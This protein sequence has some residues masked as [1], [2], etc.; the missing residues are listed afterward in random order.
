MA[1]DSKKA[2]RAVMAETKFQPLGVTVD[3]ARDQGTWHLT[4]AALTAARAFGEMNHEQAA[5]EARR[6][7]E[8][9]KHDPQE[10]VDWFDSS[11]RQLKS[12]LDSF[13][14]GR[15]RLQCGMARAAIA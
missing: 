3:E 2:A 8:E 13:E 11:S 14:A 6:L 4:F 5:E 10:M 12:A 15:H 1:K 9:D 7:L